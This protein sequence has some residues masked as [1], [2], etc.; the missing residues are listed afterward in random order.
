MRRAASL[1]AVTSVALGLAGCGTP[2]DRSQEANLVV[3]ATATT[4]EPGA[5]LP[6]G[7]DDALRAANATRRGTVTILMPSGGRTE[8]VGDPIQVAV[9]RDGTDQENDPDLITEGL[10]RIAGDLA[11]RVQRMASNQPELDLLAGLDDAARRAPRA[12]IVAVSSG[13]QT[14]GLAD[15]TGLGWDFRNDDVVANLRSHGFLP[16][17]T[18]KKVEFVGLGDTA[19][20]AQTALP[21]PMR[22][23]VESLWLDIC[24]AAGADECATARPSSTVPTVSTI[25]AKVVAVPQFTLP[26]LPAA[27]GSV[28]MPTEA[29]FAPDSADL[30]PQAQAPL[31]ALT[32][33]LL[34]RGATVDLVGRTWSVG[35]ADT[36][37]TLSEQ[38]AKAVGAALIQFGLPQQRIGSITGLGY[39]DPIHPA[40]ADAA[41]TAAANRVVVVT[42]RTDG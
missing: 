27:G 9:L 15:F 16:D 37:R 31:A 22:S 1:A 23:K 39:D 36:A 7:F 12:T 4:N 20:A 40:G 21:A 13:L 32:E 28:P 5:Q 6:G 29:L 24:H 25:A 18:G 42:V 11:R 17:L 8:Q 30:L 14:T 38:R 26:P 3:V 34:A 10:T 19:G 33:A 35:P 41:A 2:P